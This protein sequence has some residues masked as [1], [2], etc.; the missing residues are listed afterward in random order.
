MKQPKPWFWKARKAWY[1]QLNGK[2]VRLAADEKEAQREYFRLMAAEGELPPS[3]MAKALVPD[4]V[5]AFLAVKNSTRKNTLKS[6]LFYCTPFAVHFRVRRF[7][8]L[9]TP[10]VMK[11]VEGRS[12]WGDTT[13]HNAFNYV[14]ALFDWAR[15]AGYIPRNH[16]AGIENPY[17]AKRRQRGISNEEFDSMIAS[18]RDEPGRM[19]L[20]VLRDTGC[21]PGE[22]RALAA[23]HLDPEKPIAKLQPHEH[24]TGRRTGRERWLIFPAS[25]MEEVRKL[26]QLYPTGPI[27]RNRNG[28]PWKGGTM[29]NRF[30][31][32]RKRLDLPRDVVPHAARHAFITR[33]L[34]SGS[35]LALTAKI[36]GH[37]NA[38]TIQDTYY[39]P[40]E[41]DMISHV[42]EN[43]IKEG[44]TSDPAKA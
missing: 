17:I 16:M 9:R 33:M 36:V 38:N 34:N 10:E 31:E 15:D 7:A 37:S 40:Y 13:K 30:K 23:R 19:M 2:Q 22:L 43:A 1:V 6:Y 25:L 32:L 39:H 5:E 42:Q 26:A 28:D 14:A 3:E 27:L 20:R 35:P 4:V 24:K 29:Q 12:T 11:W 41:V 18:T 44:A 8:S 21:R